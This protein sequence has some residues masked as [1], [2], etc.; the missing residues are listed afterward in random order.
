LIGIDDRRSR[1]AESPAAGALF[2]ELG[3]GRRHGPLGKTKTV[4]GEQLGSD[5]YKCRSLGSCQLHVNELDVVLSSPNINCH[6]DDSIADSL[7]S[8]HVTG[9]QRR[10]RV[11]LVSFSFILVDTCHCLSLSLAL[12]SVRISQS[13]A[14]PKTV[15]SGIFWVLKQHLIS[16]YS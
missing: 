3:A 8:M 9:V 16:Y 11:S 14:L 13:F 5:Q 1:S 2:P 12:L 7:R 4:I 15:T 10:P 6:T